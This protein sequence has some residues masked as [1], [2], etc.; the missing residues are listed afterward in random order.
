MFDKKIIVILFLGAGLFLTSFIP[1][2]P[3]KD[4]KVDD[5]FSSKHSENV[6][7]GMVVLELFTSQGCSSC[8]PADELLKVVKNKYPENTFVLSYHVDYWNYIGWADPFS[9]KDFTEKQ[10]RYNK[11]FGYSG[12]Y[13]PE[14]VVNGKEHLVGSN[15][16]KVI[17]AIDKYSGIKSQNELSVQQLNRST[18]KIDF[19]YKIDGDTVGKNVRAVLLLKERITEIK[20]GEN[21][22][23]TLVNTNIVIGEKY[24]K[25][26]DGRVVGSINIPSLAINNEELV[27]ML[28][29]ENNDADITGGVKAAI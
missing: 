1:S 5:A 2:Q 8:P 15:N 27:L 22:Q 9:N 11:K 4:N 24:L 21:R 28:L 16:M 12:N 6:L 19:D 17:N 26:N 10:S 18:N 23:R 13:T 14:L 29:V 7:N 20:R 25:I 3:S